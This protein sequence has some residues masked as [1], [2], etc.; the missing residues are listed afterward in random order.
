MK[1]TTVGQPGAQ[2]RLDAEEEQGAQT[3]FFLSIRYFRSVARCLVVVTH[4]CNLSTWEAG[5]DGG[6]FEVNVVSLGRTV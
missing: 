1:G 6:G 2:H 3:E 4:A 5:Q